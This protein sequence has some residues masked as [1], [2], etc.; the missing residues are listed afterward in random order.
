MRFVNRV[1]H[2]FTTDQIRTINSS[3]LWLFK[4]MKKIALVEIPYCLKNE[5]SSEQFIKKFDKFTNDMFDVRMK[6]LTRK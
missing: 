2:E 1:I 5:S 4:V 3:L 6:L